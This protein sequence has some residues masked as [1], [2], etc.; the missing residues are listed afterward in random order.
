MTKVCNELELPM[1]QVVE[2]GDSFNYTTVEELLEK[3]KGKYPNTKRNREGLVYRLQ[4]NWNTKDFRYS[5]KVI[6]DEYLL[7]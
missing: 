2:K 3:S 7:K 1:V 6:N 4:D 5:F